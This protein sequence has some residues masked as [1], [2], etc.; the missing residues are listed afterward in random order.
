MLGREFKH[1]LRFPLLLVGSILVPVVLLL[2]FVYILGWPVE[3]R[4]LTRG[5][6]GDGL[7]RGG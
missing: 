2:L 7:E 4:E 5:A 1:T 6:G 3:G